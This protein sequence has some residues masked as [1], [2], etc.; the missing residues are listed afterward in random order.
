MTAS[1]LEDM[2]KS[3]ALLSGLPDQESRL[4]TLQQYKTELENQ[5]SPKLDSCL[6]INSDDQLL[7][8]Y[9]IYCS[10]HIEQSFIQKYCTHHASSFKEYLLLLSGYSIE[11]GPCLKLNLLSIL[12]KTFIQIFIQ[13]SLH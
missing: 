10:L 8:L 13:P 11:F 9:K 4:H 7:S 1:V 12:F 3:V 6:Q 5:L 2:T